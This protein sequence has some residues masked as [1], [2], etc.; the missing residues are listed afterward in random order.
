MSC[1]R[2]IAG[3]LLLACCRFAPAAERVD[4]ILNEVQPRSV[5]W[6]VTTGVPFP[7]GELLSADNCR[8]IDDTGAEQLLQGKPTATWDGPRGSVRWLTIDFV[9]M[10]GRKYALEFGAEV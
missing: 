5:P 4:L 1:P 6:P 9:A 8:L 10:P 3:L 2:P 7:R